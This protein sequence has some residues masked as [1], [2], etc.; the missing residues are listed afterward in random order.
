MDEDNYPLNRKDPM[1]DQSIH[2]GAILIFFSQ[3]LYLLPYLRIMVL[4][5]P[6]PI[7]CV[8]LAMTRM[9]MLP[10]RVRRYSTQRASTSTYNI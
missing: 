6:A 1:P 4:L 8:L 5:L 2:V 3:D 7:H 9:S 10:T